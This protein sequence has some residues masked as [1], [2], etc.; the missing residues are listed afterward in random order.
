MAGP[1]MVKVCVPA[2]S[3]PAHD[4]RTVALNTVWMSEEACQMVASPNPVQQRA[5]DLLKFP[6]PG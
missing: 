4:L 2:A 3:G 5:L 6:C 1:E